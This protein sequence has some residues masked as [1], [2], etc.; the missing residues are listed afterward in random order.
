[1]VETLRPKQSFERDIVFKPKI[2]RKSLKK[3][4][5]LKHKTAHEKEVK[6][7]IVII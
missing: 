6:G 1:M 4:T 5:L 3:N 7:I 2:D